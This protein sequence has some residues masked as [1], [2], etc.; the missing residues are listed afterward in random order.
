MMM[1]TPGNGSPVTASVTFP[2]ILCCGLFCANTK[3]QEPNTTKTANKRIVLMVSVFTYSLI[4][5]QYDPYR[6]K[7]FKHFI[8]QI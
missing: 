1:F 4:N 7:K 2:V 8:M 5:I 3:V 6:F